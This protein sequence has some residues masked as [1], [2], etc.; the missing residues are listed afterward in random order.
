MRRNQEIVSVL[1][2]SLKAA[3]HLVF[4]RKYLSE[5]EGG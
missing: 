3:K 4:P 2:L 5:E 1:E